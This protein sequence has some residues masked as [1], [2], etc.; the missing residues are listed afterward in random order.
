MKKRLVGFV[1]VTLLALLAPGATAQSSVERQS[2]AERLTYTKNFPGSN[3][4]FQ[5]LILNRAGE[6]VY[7][8]AADDPDPVNFILP[9]KITNQVFDL[10]KELGYF[11]NP[12]ESGLNIARMGEKTFR[13]EG[14]ETHTQTFN[15]SV[16]PVT[17]SCW[18]SSRRS[19][20]RNDCLSGW[21]TP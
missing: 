17:R 13:Y 16:N 20:N 14:A 4:A 2:S 5:Q 18:I 3:P 10:A 11:R 6:S 15:Y 7:K 12:L 8:E 19:R 21:N 9:D 1:V